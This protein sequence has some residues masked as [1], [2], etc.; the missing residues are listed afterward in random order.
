MSPDELP[1]ACIGCGACSTQCPQGIDI[2]D[3]MRKFDAL[4]KQQA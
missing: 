4:L 3:V 2:P 1:G